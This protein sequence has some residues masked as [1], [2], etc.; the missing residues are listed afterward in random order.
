MI[1]IRHEQSIIIIFNTQTAN[2]LWIDKK[3]GL[4][5]QKIITSKIDNKIKKQQLKALNPK[6][7]QFVDKKIKI[8]NNYKNIQTKALR[9]H[10]LSAPT[11]IDI[12]ITYHCNL[13]CPHCYLSCNQKKQTAM[14]L[15]NFKM[16]IDECAQLGITQIAI[17][18]GEPT[19]HPDLKQMLA[20]TRSKNII[21]NIST[22]GKNLSFNQVLYLKK[23]IGAVAFSIEYIDKKFEKQRG[24]SFQ[25]LI[26]NVNKIRL[27][28]IPLVFQV[29]LS[30]NN[31][32]HIPQ[33]LKKV[34]QFKPY[35]IIFLAFKPQ[36]RA[37]KFDQPLN[38]AN[39]EK[40]SQMI[41]QIFALCA[42]KTKLGFD[43]CMTP[44]LLQNHQTQSTRL[45]AC[46]SADSSLA[47]MPNLQV[48]P[49]SFMDSANAP[50]LKDHSILE[51]WQSAYFNNF[52]KKKTKISQKCQNCPH[53]QICQGGCP[54]FDL[55]NCQ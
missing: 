20:Y 22:N 31:L 33:L 21:P 39:P 25:T 19:L 48:L 23:Y 43:C 54:L 36:G 52:R 18:G 16:I 27:A 9:K 50:S 3:T 10:T 35:G 4:Q 41:N 55:Y 11:L 12:N 46:T 5:Y 49:C 1:I 15:E 7:S 53:L 44:A 30:K 6:L 14:S 51:I 37:K 47:I 40:V 17:G 26:N 32:T 29:V 28:K 2:E 8:I 38:K 13:N 45:L 24:F 34:L 42:D